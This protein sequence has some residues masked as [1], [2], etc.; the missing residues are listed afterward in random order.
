MMSRKSS[1]LAL[2]AS[3]LLGSM[4][5]ANADEVA[6]SG[7]N[8]KKA[9]LVTDPEPASKPAKETGEAQSAKTVTDPTPAGK[10][11]P[12]VEKA[13]ISSDPLVKDSQATTTVKTESPDAVKKTE[14]PSDPMTLLYAEKVSPGPFEAKRQLLLSSIKVAKKQ[15]FG[16]TAYLSELNKIE[17]QIKQGNASPQLEAR[18]DSIAEGLTD[19][20]KRSQILKTQRPAAGAAPRTS[21]GGGGAANAG[22]G[23]KNTD[24][25]INE[26]RQKYGDKIPAGMAGMDNNEL[27]E[28][29][30]KSDLAKE[31]L[32]KF[33]Q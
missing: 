27:K 19:Q 24:A 26:L 9:H 14:T 32:R 5:T 20:L 23:R 17:E 18:I 11:E 8:P 29:L 22:G 6:P 28:K 15:N 13:P 21:Y 1:T 4:A 30:M 2:L 33:A 3:C 16:I 7:E 31:Y 25:I 12:P 10:A